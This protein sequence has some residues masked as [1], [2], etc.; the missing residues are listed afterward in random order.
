MTVFAADVL[1]TTL[2]VSSILRVK[3][4]KQIEPVEQQSL[5]VAYMR[6]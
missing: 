3:K 2:L 5:N 4:E 6:R 1:H